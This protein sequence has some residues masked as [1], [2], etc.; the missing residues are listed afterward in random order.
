LKQTVA[1]PL[2]K[3]LLRV[4]GVKGVM[5]ASD[6]ISINKDSDVPWPILKPQIFAAIM[7][8][9]AANQ[10]AVDLEKE[11]ELQVKEENPGEESE[12]VQM[13]K[14]I[15]E[16]RIRPAVQDDGGDI[17]FKA[18]KD[19]VVF[20]KMQGSCSSC[21]SSQLT[22]KSG[23][24]R[25]LMHWVPEVTNVMPV[26]DDDLE[27]INLEAFKKVDEAASKQEGASA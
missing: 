16:T 22:L 23:I 13:I 6:F 24:E 2:A 19:G 20:V 18:F 14:E 11:K 3:A 25:M 12:V 4:E 7:D 8:F 15:L 9:F 27:K 21:P 1:S 10:P 17:Q 5:L 26:S